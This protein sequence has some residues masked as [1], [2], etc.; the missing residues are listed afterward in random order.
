MKIP[1]TGGFS[2]RFLS[3][4]LHKTDVDIRIIL[5]DFLLVLLFGGK[6][7]ATRVILCKNCPLEELLP[8]QR[9]QR[10][11]NKDWRSFLFIIFIELST[12]FY[13]TF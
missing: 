9:R 1:S 8:A 4:F 10:T 2:T 12:V 3:Y 11:G 5:K 13:S 6:T 7:S